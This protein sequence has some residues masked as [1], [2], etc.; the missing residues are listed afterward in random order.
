MTENQLRGRK[1]ISAPPCGKQ[2]PLPKGSDNPS[3]SCIKLGFRNI[4][5]FHPPVYSG[6]LRL[7]SCGRRTALSICWQGFAKSGRSSGRPR[8][9]FCGKFKTPSLSDHPRQCVFVWIRKLKSCCSARSRPWEGQHEGT[10]GARVW[11]FFSH[12]SVFTDSFECTWWLMTL[13]P[14]HIY[15]M[16]VRKQSWESG[17]QC[18]HFPHQKWKKKKSVMLNLKQTC[19]L[20]IGNVTRKNDSSHTRC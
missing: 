15:K 14:P 9:A 19:L 1:K 13:S 4:I 8:K 17:G 10:A 7:E 20:R 3:G 5:F 11:A 16:D 12:Y 18:R 6:T 2:L